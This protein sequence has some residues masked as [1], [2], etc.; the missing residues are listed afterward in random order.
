MSTLADVTS[1]S[2][3]Y[4]NTHRERSQRARD[5]WPA[6]HSQLR[7]IHGEGLYCGKASQGTGAHKTRTLLIT[8]LSLYVAGGVSVLSC[9]LLHGFDA[10]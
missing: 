6:H 9:M 3:L 2:Q 8:G 7:G 1:C 5:R 10:A 4:I